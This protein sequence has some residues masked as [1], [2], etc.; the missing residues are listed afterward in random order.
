MLCYAINRAGYRV[1]R[2]PQSESLL[3]SLRRWFDPTMSGQQQFGGSRTWPC[4]ETR[5]LI[6]LAKPTSSSERPLAPSE[7]SVGRDEN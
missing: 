7:L 3:R 2:S 6:M 1:R 5:V 4:I